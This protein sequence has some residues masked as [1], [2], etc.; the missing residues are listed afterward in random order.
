VS[1]QGRDSRR[2]AL[3]AERHRLFYGY[4]TWGR[5]G[6]KIHLGAGGEKKRAPDTMPGNERCCLPT[7]GGIKR[8]LHSAVEKKK[9]PCRKKKDCFIPAIT[10]F[11]GKTLTHPCPR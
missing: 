2:F 7:A 10:P 8:R 3:R 6:G 9:G 4:E 5:K 1:L 11:K